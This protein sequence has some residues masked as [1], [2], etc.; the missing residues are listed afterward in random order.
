MI[1]SA[2][3][4]YVIEE[5]LGQGGMGTV[6]RARDTRLQRPVAIKVL[7]AALTSDEDRRRR[8]FQEARA[9]AAINH[10]AVAQIYDVDEADGV[11][12]I[13]MEFVEGRT[14][15]KLV[16]DREL[17]LLASLDIGIQVSDG[18]SKAHEAGIVHR[19]IKSE[20]IMVTREGHAKI[21]DFGLA[22]LDPLRSQ[23]SAPGQSS[24]QHMSQMATIAQMT[25]AQ[26]QTGM[27]VGTIAYMSPEQARGRVIDSR[28]DIFSLGVTLYEMATGRLPFTGDSPLDTMHAIAFEETRP[29]TSVRQN[30]PP[31]L[32]RI[33]NR[34]LRKRPEDRYASA[35]ELASD[36]R[37]LRKDVDSGVTR[38]VPLTDRLRDEFVS[39]KNLRAGPWPWILAGAA[40]LA[41]LLA[42]YFVYRRGGFWGPALALLAVYWVA[43]S[44][45]GRRRRLLKWFAGRLA[46][47]PEVRLV[48]ADGHNATVIVDRMQARLYMRINS[49]LDAVN[50]KL[51]FGQPV[52]L[53]LRD[54]VS[55]EEF[56]TILEHGGVL[57]LRDD[58]FEAESRSPGSRAGP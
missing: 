45:R 44:I 26:T 21:L 16:E 9:A 14:V 49:T 12:F 35:G 25:A 54:D 52:R 13:A 31:E 53:T 30:L 23:E 19:D 20:N 58:V 6:Y 42:V 50:K 51:L 29:L 3:K 32:Q 38:A 33:V 48:A 11:T 40:A 22:K 46:K 15:R 28:S 39:L 8:F 18:L 43:R 55:A 2:V 10:P 37:S 34:C 41:V 1:G 17:D 5:L 56:K 4:H 36:L 27:V 57:H 47:L 24:E 7:G